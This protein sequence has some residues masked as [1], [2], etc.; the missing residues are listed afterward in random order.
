V[1][2]YDNVAERIR[3][4]QLKTA[5]VFL[6]LSVNATLAEEL[7]HITPGIVRIFRDDKPEPAFLEEGW[8]YEN[9]DKDQFLR[10][11]IQR[12]NPERVFAPK[13]LQEAV[14]QVI[15]AV[16]A[17]SLV[18]VMQNDLHCGNIGR[19][20]GAGPANISPKPILQ[21]RG[22]KKDSP[23]L[24]VSMKTR[25]VIID[26][27][28][29]ELESPD[30]ARKLDTA[31]FLIKLRAEFASR[32]L[33]HLIEW[34]D[35]LI[36]AFKLPPANSDAWLDL[37]LRLRDDYDLSLIPDPFTV[38]R[39]LVA[40]KNGTKSVL[41][42]SVVVSEKPRHALPRQLYPWSTAADVEGNTYKAP[43]VDLTTI[44]KRL[45]EI[46]KPRKKREDDKLYLAAKEKLERIPVMLRSTVLQWRY[47]TRAECY[48]NRLK[49]SDVRRQVFGNAGEANP[50]F[51]E[52]L[53]EPLKGMELSPL[54]PTNQRLYTTQLLASFVNGRHVRDVHYMGL[55]ICMQR[56]LVKGLLRAKGL[57]VA[58][59]QADPDLDSKRSTNTT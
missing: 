22:R 20:K 46:R 37:D 7:Q 3:N 41:F 48:D 19:V 50:L 52:A 8:K 26:Y 9:V 47:G 16:R 4:S 55:V 53:A 49:Q 1:Y 39:D 32:G 57:L 17:M 33:V 27:D 59:R 5:Q 15:L 14:I 36:Q 23:S 54:A 28:Q 43:K 29:A 24:Y 30:R 40:P 44:I 45:R 58:R 51:A 34:C 21:I 42:P 6:H 13:K 18:S 2:Y 25:W 10:M 56:R 12:L 11:Y 35:N 38:L 31:A